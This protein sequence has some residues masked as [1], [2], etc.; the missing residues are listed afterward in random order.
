VRRARARARG[1]SAQPSEEENSVKAAVVYWSRTG[2]TEQVARVIADTLAGAGLEV[3][4]RRV[5]EAQ[6]VDWFDYD[7]YCLGFPSYH[8]SPPKPVDDLLRLKARAYGRE[9]RIKPKAPPIPDKHAL[10]FCTYS[11]PHTGIDEALPPVKYAGQYFAHVGIPVLAEWCTVG[12][13]HGSL[14]NS[15]QGCLGD[16]RG[17][18]NADD[19]D[20]IRQKTLAL[21]ERL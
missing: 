17:R 20:Q 14:E 2:N 4:Y 3:D 12:E 21:I 18:P 7:L 6:D 11:G 8:W 16:I 9:G 15:T 19:L 1:A 5:E 13:F 10:I